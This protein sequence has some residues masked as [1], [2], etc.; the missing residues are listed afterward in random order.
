MR[1]P[2][3]A[4][5]AIPRLVVA[6]TASGAG[7]TTVTV[8]LAAALRARGLSVAVFKCGPDYLD[9]SYHA[10]ASGRPCH[11]LDGWMMG[12]EAVL[13]TF[14]HGAEGADVALVEG[15]MGLFDGASASLPGGP[16]ST[17]EIA[18]WLDAPVL[19]CADAS[20][21][22]G[23]IAALARG[24][25]DFDPALRVRGLVCNRVGGRP[26]LDLLREALRT[27]PIVGGLP[28]E[29]A[30]AFPER[31]LGLHAAAEALPQSVLDAW[32]ERTA[33]FVDLDA[34]LAI[35]RS[36]PPLPSPPAPRS[37]GA[38]ASRCR[39]G[40]AMDEAFHFYY[41]YNLRLLEAH[42]AALVPFSP[43]RD[44]E[45]P[46]LDGIY[47]GGGYPELHA[48]ALAGNASM[49]R[50][51]AAFGAR[52]GPVY[53]E[54]GGFMYLCAAIRTLDGR[55]HPMVG[56]FDA[57]A[58]LRDRPQA[59]GYAEVATTA[60][61]LLGPAGTSF[62]GHEFRYSELV[63]GARA[64]DLAYEVRGR[65]GDPPRR[66]GHV[67]GNVLGSWVHAHW[68]SSPAAAGA[69]VAACAASAGRRG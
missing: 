24:Y 55:D 61:T 30:L 32:A 35:A 65:P 13:A 66:E 52:G 18:R 28:A 51:L 19:L 49:R 57:V 17:A 38:G 67:R 27:P 48:A 20:G 8:G 54:C 41:E 11:N 50:S 60:P 26:H 10:R 3:G 43:V 23:S 46:D 47:L 5:L 31:H 56:V 63:P 44:G 68:A 42:G 53:A 21:M 14:A 29:E 37:T 58:A 40:V 62:R 34:V 64:H 12:R 7:K 36:A 33:A 59:L 45:L 9:P 2:M 16:G 6:G 15:M 39:I 1:V 22:A 25:A 69:F 4:P